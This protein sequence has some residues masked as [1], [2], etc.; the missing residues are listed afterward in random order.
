MNETE[1]FLRERWYAQK[2]IGRLL[3]D[4]TLAKS[5]YQ[6]A[7]TSCGLSCNY[8]KIKTK[9]QRSTLSPVEFSAI[10]VIDQFRAEMESIERKLAAER[11]KTYL[12]EQVLKAAALKPR[13]EEYIRIRYFENRTVEA[14]AQRL[15]CSIATCGRLRESAL[16][17]VEAARGGALLKE[18]EI[19]STKQ[20]KGE[21][22]VRTNRKQICSDSRY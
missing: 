12:I 22:Y 15:Y 17:K 2:C 11:G 6:E 9:K 21:T 3:I 8:D 14:T 10:L 4:L 13:E 20:Q 18:G 7:Y 5:A 16:S 1:Q 19:R